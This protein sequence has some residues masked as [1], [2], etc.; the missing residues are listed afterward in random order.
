VSKDGRN[1]GEPL[2]YGEFSNIRNSPVL[3]RKMFETTS[4]RY[5]K[6]VA[7]REINEL[8]FVSIAELGIITKGE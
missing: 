6:F 3:Q 4:G 1:W 5:I 7:D 2:S 8:E